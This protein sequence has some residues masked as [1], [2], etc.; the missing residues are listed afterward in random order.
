MI[1]PGKENLLIKPGVFSL[2]TLP[3]KATINERITDV[4]LHQTNGRCPS[5][6]SDIRGGLN[7]ELWEI[8]GSVDSCIVFGAIFFL[9]PCKMVI[10]RSVR[11]IVTGRYNHGELKK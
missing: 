4:D 1:L 3:Y 10:G 8:P 7:N 2:E 11:R 5:R 9:N 6:C